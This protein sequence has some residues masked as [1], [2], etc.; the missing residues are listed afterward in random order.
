M[1]SIP[2]VRVPMSAKQQHGW[3]TWDTAL[4][5]WIVC[6]PSLDRRAFIWIRGDF[7]A[8]IVSRIAIGAEVAFVGEKLGP[9][10]NFCTSLIHNLVILGLALIEYLVML[11]ICSYKVTRKSTTLI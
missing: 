1:G 2:A 8:S 4:P 6:H 10:K 5:T 3:K 7:L 11:R 9:R